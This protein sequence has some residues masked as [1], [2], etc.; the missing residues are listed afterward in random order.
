M[1]KEKI[2][3]VGSGNWGSAIARIAGNNVK[4][5][6]DM[7]DEQVKMWVF[8]EE[9]EGKKLTEIINEEHENRKYLPGVALGENVVAIP[10]IGEAVKGAT[11]LIFVM[12]HQFLVKT[13]DQM[14]GKVTKGIRAVSLAK[15]VEVN[16][17]DIKLFA[18]IISERLEISCAALS[19]ANIANEVARDRFSETTIGVRKK[20]DGDM[21]KKLFTTPKFRVSIVDDV[22][23]VS[24]CGALKNIVAVGSGLADG[25]EWGNNSKAAI[26]RIGLMEM[27][28]FCQEFFE[29]VK[30][31]TFLEQ[32]AG[33]ADVITSCLGG[34]NM[35]VATAFVKE[36][37]SFEELEKE[38]LNGQKLQGIHTAKEINTFLKARNRVDAYPL[39]TNVYR[40]CWEGKPAEE[41][42][43]GL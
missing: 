8:E 41:L 5:N 39:F 26:M 30:E 32:S 33:V 13:L 1:G 11:V 17:S 25:L 10:D 40:I 23:G 3:I 2:T 42:T 18:D 36:K 22:A 9:F 7:F 12:P 6:P 15:G 19:G 14:E 43:D 35:K 28:S 24:L 31:E 37:R 4:Q 38:M 34:R 21:W 16:G 27:K 20:E 29:G